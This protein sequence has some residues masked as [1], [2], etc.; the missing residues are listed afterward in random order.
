MM[1]SVTFVR[2]LSRVTSNA[3]DPAADP[4]SRFRLAYDRELRGRSELRNGDGPVVGYGPLWWGAFGDHGFVTYQHLG[5]VAGA[6]LDALIAATIAYYRDETDLPRF[7]WKTRGHDAPADLTDRLLAHGFV[8][9]EIETVMIG[10]ADACAVDVALPEG[11]R[12]VRVGDASRD[13]AEMAAELTAAE[14]MQ[15][16]VFGAAS[17]SSAESMAARLLES[18]QTEEFWYAAAPDGQVVCAGRLSVVEGTSFAGLWGGSTHPDW[19]GRGIYRAL[20]AARARSALRLGASLLMSDCTAMS[21][22][23][24]ARAGLIPVT[25]TTPYLWSRA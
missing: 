21:R 22:P 8:A 13:L 4:A 12:L 20:V 24:L 6:D 7:E 10:S 2:T 25:T 11:V 15:A 1:T 14:R 23:I 17:M 3:A 9:D 19:R 16:E 5:G 18:P